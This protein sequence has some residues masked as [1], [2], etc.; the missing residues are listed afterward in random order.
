LINSTAVFS[1][2]PG[3]GEWETLLRQGVV[4]NATDPL[5]HNK[6][7]FAYLKGDFSPAELEGVKKTLATG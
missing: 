5:L 7:A 3:T 1:P 2:I 6:I 4:T